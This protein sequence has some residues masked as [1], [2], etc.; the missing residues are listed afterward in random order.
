MTSLKIPRAPNPHYLNEEE[1][2]KVRED[3][4]INDEL[5]QKMQDIADSEETDEIVEV[6]NLKK[7]YF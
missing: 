6:R 3:F 1:R 2:Q 7:L 4:D 5:L